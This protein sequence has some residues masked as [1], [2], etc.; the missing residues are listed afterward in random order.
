[1]W[2][3]ME[4]DCSV[5]MGTGAHRRLSNLVASKRKIMPAFK[6]VRNVVTTAI[7]VPAVKALARD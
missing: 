1:M 5:R 4:H 7:S 6:F 2:R 3:G